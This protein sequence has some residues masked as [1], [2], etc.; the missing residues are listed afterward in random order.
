MIGLIVV[1]SLL[2]LGVYLYIDAIKQLIK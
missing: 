1:S 2:A